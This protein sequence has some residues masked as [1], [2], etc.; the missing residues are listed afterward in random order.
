MNNTNL[1][2]ALLN[3]E[4][5]ILDQ[6]DLLYVNWSECQIS[7]DYL[8]FNLRLIN[9]YEEV[10]NEIRTSINNHIKK[11]KDEAVEVK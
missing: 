2:K 1:Q 10:R 8:E 7:K 9:E 4:Q 11:L 6:F 5:K 3:L